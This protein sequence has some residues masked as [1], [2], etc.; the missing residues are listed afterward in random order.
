MVKRTRLAFLRAVKR[1]RL[2]FLRAVEYIRTYPDR[3]TPPPYEGPKMRTWKN[4][5]EVTDDIT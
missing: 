4:G 5:V 2:A 1:I 3:G